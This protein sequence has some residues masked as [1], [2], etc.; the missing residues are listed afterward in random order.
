MECSQALTP[1]KEALAVAVIAASRLL[2]GRDCPTATT[3]SGR[4][5]GCLTSIM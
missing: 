3:V 4:S 2:V 5:F 1:T